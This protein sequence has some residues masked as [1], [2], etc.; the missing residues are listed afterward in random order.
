MHIAVK[1]VKM[2]IILSLFLAFLPVFLWGQ[3]SKN[4]STSAN[5]LIE[6]AIFSEFE[7]R[8]N[9]STPQKAESD[10][11]LEKKK[12][13]KSKQLSETSNQTLIPGNSN[14]QNFSNNF[15]N[16]LSASNYSEISWFNKYTSFRNSYLT[17]DGKI[18]EAE[19]KELL[20]ICEQ[21]SNFIPS[22]FYNN[23]IL[24]KQNR[25]N[26]SSIQYLKKAQNIDPQ[27]TLLLTE[28]AWLAERSGNVEIRS[29]ATSQLYKSGGIS[30]LSKLNAELIIRSI[31]EGSLLISNGEYDTYPM[32]LVAGSK[33]IYIV[34]LAM[35]A[36]KY[37]LSKQLKSWDSKIILPKGNIEENELFE[38]VLSSEKPV[39]TTLSLRKSILNKWS[40]KLFVCGN[41]A[42]LSHQNINNIDR[43]KGFYFQNSVLEQIVAKS[44]WQSDPYAPALINLTPGIKVLLQ[45]NQL[46]EQEK[47]KLITLENKIKIYT[48]NF[49]N[50]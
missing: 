50:K 42:S 16:Q 49:L 24:L 3:A 9:S 48:S 27:N 43:L 38:I 45:S 12:P 34:S 6:P 28:A 41:F 17:N 21:S 7:N 10:A 32:W 35:I 14:N 8:S 22:T 36:D 20:Q 37:W 13:L 46:T 19:N 1:F 15:S 33:N 26:N 18:D 30:E 40:Q 29:Q 2:K 25:N 47:Q 44:S 39:Y 5:K 4:E 23:Y 11:T 31:P